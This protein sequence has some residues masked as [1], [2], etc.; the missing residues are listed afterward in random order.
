MHK[1][2][3]GKHVAHMSDADHFLV[4][5][6]Q[7]ADNVH[8]AIKHRNGVRYT[9]VERRGITLRWLLSLFRILLASIRGFRRSLCYGVGHPWRI[10]SQGP[11]VVAR[12]IRISR[13]TCLCVWPAQNQ[14]S[15]DGRDHSRRHPSRRSQRLKTGP[16]LGSLDNSLQDWV[17]AQQEGDVEQA[18]LHFAEIRAGCQAGDANGGVCSLRLFPRIDHGV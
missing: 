11:R 12:V 17:A 15:A 14:R 10:V 8:N 16:S 6:D 13:N 4:G 2:R 3:A 7:S 5:F 1:L 18:L 9:L